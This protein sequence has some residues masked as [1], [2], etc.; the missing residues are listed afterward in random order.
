MSSKKLHRHILPI[1]VLSVGLLIFSIM[2]I[3]R[4]TIT[5]TNHHPSQL[6]SARLFT[7]RA[8]TNGLFHISRYKVPN[9]Q[10]SIR[11]DSADQTT[12]GLAVLVDAGKVTELSVMINGSDQR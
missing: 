6:L 4:F 10:E 8:T 12:T 2:V 1:I 5:A 9:S 7:I 3:N 11:I